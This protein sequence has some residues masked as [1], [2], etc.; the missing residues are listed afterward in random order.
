MALAARGP[1]EPFSGIQIG[2][3]IFPH[4]LRGDILHAVQPRDAIREDKPNAELRSASWRSR[5]FLA[6]GTPR[7]LVGPLAPVASRF[8]IWPA[9]CPLKWQRSEP[10]HVAAPTLPN[11]V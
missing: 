6:S 4:R 3:K 5:R 7:D 1:A 10:P 2:L 11:A 9:H 8:F